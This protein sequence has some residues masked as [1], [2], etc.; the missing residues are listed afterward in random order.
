M[1]WVQGPVTVG[2]LCEEMINQISQV[3]T[4]KKNAASA[5]SEAFLSSA[6]NDTHEDQLESYCKQLK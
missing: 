6:D 1:K 3:K 5:I 4:I 2:A